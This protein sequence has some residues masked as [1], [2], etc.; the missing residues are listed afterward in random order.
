LRGRHRR[1]L[2]VKTRRDA[3]L[4]AIVADWLAQTK[5]PNAVRLQLDIDPYSF[6]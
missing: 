4:Q 5:L 2:L 3:N 1:R 6:L